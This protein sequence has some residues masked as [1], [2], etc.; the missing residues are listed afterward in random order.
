M[1]VYGLIYDR[2]LVGALKYANSIETSNPL[3]ATK[4]D[5]AIEELIILSGMRTQKS[6]IKTA[7]PII[8]EDNQVDAPN[9]IS[10]NETIAQKQLEEYNLLKETYFKQRAALNLRKDQTYTLDENLLE[11]CFAYLSSIG[12]LPYLSVFR[13]GGHT[14]RTI[15][16]GLALAKNAAMY[17]Y[18]GQ[19]L[20][21]DFV[22]VL[23]GYEN[24]INTVDQVAEQFSKLPTKEAKEVLEEI[25]KIPDKR[26]HLAII[27]LY[28]K[29]DIIN[30]LYGEFMK[31]KKTTLKGALEQARQD[32][33]GNEH[34]LALQKRVNEIRDQLDRT[35][36]RIGKGMNLT[37]EESFDLLKSIDKEN[38]DFNAD[39]KN[40]NNMKRT[41]DYEETF[42]RFIEDKVD[43]AKKL[44]QVEDLAKTKNLLGKEV[45]KNKI[46]EMIENVLSK[47]KK[48]LP[49]QQIM[50]VLGPALNIFTV[51]TDL[52]SLYDEY[53][54]RGVTSYFVCKL[55]AAIANIVSMFPATWAI[56]ASLNLIL[57]FGLCPTVEANINKNSRENKAAELGIIKDYQRND[58]KAA[59][60]FE[61]ATQN[62]Q[63]TDLDPKD[64]ILLKELFAEKNQKQING[65]LFRQIRA[66][67]QKNIN[68][69]NLESPFKTYAVFLDEMMNLKKAI[70]DPNASIQ[71]KVPSD[72]KSKIFDEPKVD[73]QKLAPA[74]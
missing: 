36:A 65:D 71:W 7:Q 20:K 53:K 74:Q 9:L 49:I 47:V 12:K 3:F 45:S 63:F 66:E 38:T 42:N 17:V 5:S 70:E 35:T 6:F 52:T 64:Q 11:Q 57:N 8:P 16:M 58:A 62:V 51:W 2:G 72:N 40:Q 31:V 48:N 34:N 4:I 15:C 54:T 23:K 28:R 69:G 26:M 19:K 37:T 30:P 59:E 61:K 60:T 21:K 13:Q 1:D 67:M 25:K 73:T 24:N 44:D 14:V 68:T 27:D 10:S 43:T 33:V 46:T 39:P 55:L 50:K 32:L 56:G 18:F 29:N 41:T 22:E